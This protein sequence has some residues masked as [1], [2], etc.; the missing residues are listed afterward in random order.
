MPED[1]FIVGYDNSELS[2]SAEPEITSFDSKVEVIT[3][4]AVDALIKVLEGREA[5][6]KICVSGELIQRETTKF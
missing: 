6:K 5:P 3:A 1:L 2:I 4:K